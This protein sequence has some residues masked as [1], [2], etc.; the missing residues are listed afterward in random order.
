M[1]FIKANSM[2]EKEDIAKKIYA[3]SGAKKI[4]LQC[5][6][7]NE[8]KYIIPNRLHWATNVRCSNCKRL[9]IE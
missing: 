4:E 9:F 6:H 5:P 8:L 7:C 3:G 2:Q 1:P